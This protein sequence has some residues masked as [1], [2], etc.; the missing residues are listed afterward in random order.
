MLPDP[1]PPPA[2]EREQPPGYLLLDCDLPQLQ[3]ET[4]EDVA[5]VARAR[6]DA[7]CDCTADKRALRAWK[8]GDGAAIDPPP[9]VCQDGESRPID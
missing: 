1:A 6:L 8:A 9:A 4:W 3:G 7:L 5:R 2:I